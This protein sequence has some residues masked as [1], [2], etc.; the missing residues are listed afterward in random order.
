MDDILQVLWHETELT[1]AGEGLVMAEND[2]NR[3]LRCVATVDDLLSN[4]TV[5][6]VTVRCQS[7][8][9]H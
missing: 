7:H 8:L 9:S 5:A 4:V 1:A 6:V 3:R 2:D